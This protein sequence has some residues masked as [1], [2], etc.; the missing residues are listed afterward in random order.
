[1]LPLAYPTII[2]QSKKRLQIVQTRSNP[3]FWMPKDEPMILRFDAL[4]ARLDA[5]LP[6]LAKWIGL[7]LIHI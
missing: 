7:S 4:V 2:Q 6:G 5:I 3:C 1:M